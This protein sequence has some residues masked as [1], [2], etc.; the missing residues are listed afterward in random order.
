MTEIAR[1]MT[2]EEIVKGFEEL[3]VTRVGDTPA[4]R[5]LMRAAATLGA[6]FT[7]PE[8]VEAVLGHAKI[9]AATREPDTVR[10]VPYP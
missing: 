7:L 1:P 4:K 3:M 9:H 8:L 6:K 10:S 2:V 5:A